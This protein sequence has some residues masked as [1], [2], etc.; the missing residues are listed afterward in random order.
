ML[1]DHFLKCMIQAAYHVRQFYTNGTIESMTIKHIHNA[2]DT[3]KQH[4]PFYTNCA[5]HGQE[6]LSAKRRTRSCSQVL[7]FQLF[8][9]K[10]VLILEGQELRPGSIAFRLPPMS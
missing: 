4:S 1:H 7:V 3:A 6:K 8:T 5:K 9:Q 10:R 2:K